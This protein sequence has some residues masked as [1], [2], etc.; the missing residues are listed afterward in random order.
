LPRRLGEEA[1][2]F[3]GLH[4]ADVGVPITYQVI[5]K[6]WPEKV[7]VYMD[8]LAKNITSDALIRVG[9]MRGGQQYLDNIKPG[10][11]EFQVPMG[12]AIFMIEGDKA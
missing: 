8:F 12:L 7:N 2:F 1:I 5:R 3:N 11:P 10:A 9:M 4:M 6:L